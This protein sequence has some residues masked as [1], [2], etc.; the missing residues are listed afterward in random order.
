AQAPR[1]AARSKRLARHA[2]SWRRA[3]Q[4][5]HSS[6]ASRRLRKSRPRRSLL[7]LAREPAPQ[8]RGLAVDA[9]ASEIAAAQMAGIPG[10]RVALAAVQ[11]PL[12]VEDNHTPAIKFELQLEAGI[13]QQC[14]E[15]PVSGVVGSRVTG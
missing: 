5:M 3:P 7:R 4:S 2:P 1:P 11:D 8:Q 12:I 13:A 15:A 14:T 10:G 6:H 9:V